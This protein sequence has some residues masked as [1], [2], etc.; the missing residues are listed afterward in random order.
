VHHNTV[1]A[2]AAGVAVAVL[3]H[4]VLRTALAHAQH[5]DRARRLGEDLPAALDLIGACLAAGATLSEALLD[6][7]ATLEGELARLLA[8]VGHALRRGAPDTVAWAAFEGSAVPPAGAALAR[9]A[10][11]S[12]T[13]GSALEPWIARLAEDVRATRA[14]DAAGAAHRAGVLAV[15]PLG[16]CA[17]PAYVLLAVV[18]AV[19]GLLRGLH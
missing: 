13:S 2:L 1:L 14:A 17:L 16:L 19:V 5:A 9:A 4:R 12:A 8:G 11:R 7:G 18:P 15:L 6:V 3:A 10:V